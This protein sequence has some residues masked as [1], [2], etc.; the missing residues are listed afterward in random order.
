MSVCVEPSDPTSNMVVNYDMGKALAYVKKLNAEQDVHITVTHLLAHGLTWGLYKMRRDVGRLRFGYF[1][2][3]KKLG[4][5]VLVDVEGGKDL[6]PVTIWDGHKKTLFEVA[7]DIAEQAGRARKGKDVGH[8]RRSKAADFIPSFIAQPMGFCLSYIG[9]AIGIPLP[10]FGLG[11]DS[12][13]HV[14]LTNVGSFGYQM[15][16]AP[17][18]PPVHQMALLCAGQIE[19]RA[20]IDEDDKVVVKQ[21][22]TCVG[23]GDHR[24][25]DAATFLPLFRALRGYVEDPANFD[26]SKYPGAPH[27]S[28]L[29]AQ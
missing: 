4:L 12:T 16:F 3:A 1:K 7:K 2:A 22:M 10:P 5:T 17:L 19:K 29:K 14:V 27:H 15:G 18:C 25:G 11:P 21:M 13:G 9:S 20:M 6:V 28:E 23:T 26:E 8:V 24:Y